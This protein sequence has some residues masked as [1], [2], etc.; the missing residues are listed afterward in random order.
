MK[1]LLVKALCLNTL[2]LL[3]IVF[4]RQANLLAQD[5]SFSQ[6]QPLGAAFNPAAVAPS[7]YDGRAYLAHRSQWLAAAVPYSA[8]L[9]GAEIRRDIRYKWLPNLGLG[10][11]LIDDN[12]G[13]NALRNN[14]VMLSSNTYRY[15]DPARKHRLTFGI[16]AGVRI[17]RIGANEFVYEN[18]FNT[19]TQ[20]FDPR[21]RSG[22]V[23]A[24]NQQM[25]WQMNSGIAY[26]WQ[27]NDKLMIGASGAFMNLNRPSEQ[28]S[29]L[30]IE[31]ASRQSY[32]WVATFEAI[33][34]LAPGLAVEPSLFLNRQ[35]RAGEWVYGSWFNFNGRDENRNKLQLMPG[36][37][38]RHGNSVIPGIKLRYKSWEAA[39]TYDAVFGNLNSVNTQP[40][41]GGGLGTIEFSVQYLILNRLKI[42]SYPKPCN[43]I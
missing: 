36:I 29:T 11:M 19:E 14:W 16:S 10:F 20:K 34:V 5:Y 21:N 41:L 40:L 1:N 42:K 12:L 31:V 25:R 30:P 26:Q 43:T 8:T 4:G 32:R 33:Y 23:F 17:I 22:E 38:L 35:G 6:Y 15:L 9:A 3:S 28:F 27:V 18:Q 37:F 2:A 39:A 13:Q 24:N 7:P